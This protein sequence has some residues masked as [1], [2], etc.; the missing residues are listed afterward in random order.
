MQEPTEHPWVDDG[1]QAVTQELHKHI[2]IGFSPKST[3]SKKLILSIGKGL[4]SL[5]FME[6]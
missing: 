5:T 2:D 1:H 6:F 4:F 3:N